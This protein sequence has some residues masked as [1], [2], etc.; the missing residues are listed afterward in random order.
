M[1]RE[2]RRRGDILRQGQGKPLVLPELLL[3]N[4][5]YRFYCLMTANMIE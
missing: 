1:S 4:A 3:R 2:E 5:S